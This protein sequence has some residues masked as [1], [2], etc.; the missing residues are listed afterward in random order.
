MKHETT[1]RRQRLHS[2][3]GGF[4]G[5]LYSSQ[6]SQLVEFAMVLPLLALIL[7]GTIEFGGAFTLKHRI[8]NATREG[9]RFAI[10]EASA[11]ISQWPAV[12]PTTQ[13][14]LNDILTYMTNT[15]VNVCGLTSSSGASSTPSYGDWVFSSSCSDTGGQ[16]SIEINRGITFVDSRGVTVT[17]A[18]VTISRPYKWS[19]LMAPLVG[20]VGQLS[21]VSSYSMMED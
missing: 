15:G 6:G 1:S 4:L 19:L 16:I 10:D 7:M 13:A 12:A 14:I 9:V 17:A 8:G 18:K 5:G 20:A 11:D 21:T 3:R 2:P